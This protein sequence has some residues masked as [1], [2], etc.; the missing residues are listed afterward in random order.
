VW[1]DIGLPGEEHGDMDVPATIG[2]KLDNCRLDVLDERCSTS[3][4]DIESRSAA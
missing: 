3:E 4:D 2:G 1:G